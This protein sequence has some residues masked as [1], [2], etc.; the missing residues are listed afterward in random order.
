VSESKIER[1]P[2]RRLGRMLD[3]LLVGWALFIVYGTTLPLSFSTTWRDLP[4][5]VSEAL[6]GLS[7]RPSIPDLVSNVA[8]FAPLGLL[9]AA[10]VA[11]RGRGWVLSVTLAALAGGALSL[12]VE[13]LQL[14]LPRITSPWD[15]LA[16]TAGAAAGALV[17]WPVAAHLWPGLASPLR[18]AVVRRPMATLALIAILALFA[19]ALEPFRLSIDVGLIKRAVK[20]ARLVPFGET[21][22]GSVVELRAWALTGEL[23][24]WILLGGLIGL[25]LR[26]AGR[27]GAGALF[28]AALSGV[29]V[30]AAVEM[31]QLAAIG[32]T[33]DATSVVL[34][35]IGTLIGAGCTLTADRPPS[36]WATPALALWAAAI[37][38]DSWTPPRLTLPDELPWRGLIPFYAYYL[39]TDVNAV[40]DLL[41]EA[42]RFLPLGAL[43]AA[44]GR[45]GGQL[46]AGLAGLGFGLLLEAGQLFL[47]DRTPDV[48]DALSASAGAVLGCTMARRAREIWLEASGSGAPDGAAR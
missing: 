45:G 10:R 9:L 23:L 20:A 43:V 2:H 36:A 8:L 7:H 19:A 11:I 34:A 47:V 41:R 25:A 22:D 37:L 42:S 46:R 44:R 12:G 6:G 38:L 27:R 24:W 4:V 40:V 30:A 39:D 17:G 28:G 16:N 15:L 13:L 3:L 18:R 48:T 5:A 35:A 32:R 26:E 33:T 1:D 14:F 29:A 21:V 31:A